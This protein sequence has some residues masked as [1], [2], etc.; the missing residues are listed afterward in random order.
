MVNGIEQACN[1][2]QSGHNIKK[3]N[4]KYSKGFWSEIDTN[5]DPWILNVERGGVTSYKRF[6]LDTR[7][8]IEKW[9]VDQQTFVNTQNRTKAFHDS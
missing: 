5:M 8:T 3:R 9:V 2:K 7:C 6:G 1:V 4:R